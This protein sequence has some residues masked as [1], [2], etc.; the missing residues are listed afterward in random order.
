M[1][2]RIELTI[3]PEY[4]NWGLY[5]GIR[6]F[7]QNARDEETLNNHPMDILHNPKRNV[8]QIR[9]YGATLPLET[10][11]LGK[12]QKR[13]NDA[14]IGEFGE[15][16][17]L[18]CLGLIRRG[19]PVKI[20]TGTEMWEPAIVPSKQ[21][22]GCKVLAFDVHGNRAKG[23]AGV[24]VEV[25]NIQN[26]AWTLV[27][28]MF[29]WLNKPNEEQ[30]VDC[31]NGRI[32][33]EEKYKGRLY[34][35]G[36]FVQTLPGNYRYGYDMKE[37]K[38]D[39]DR[40]VAEGWSLRWELDRLWRQA[41]EQKE[42]A[43]TVLSLLNADA[44]DTA[45]VDPAYMGAEAKEALAEI[46]KAQHGEEALPVAGIG[47]SAKLMHVGKRGV[48]VSKDAHRVLK[49][50][51]GDAGAAL[52]KAEN[53]VTIFYGWNDLEDSEREL[54]TKVFAAL[55]L[56]REDIVLDKVRVVDFRGDSTL[57]KWQGGEVY[58][59]RE[60]LQDPAELIAT[61]A[62]EFAHSEGSDGDVFHEREIE[63]IL[64]VALWAVL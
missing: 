55:S 35:K 45:S 33:L 13:G 2:R 3:D 18:G 14:A 61:V 28:D 20:W 54:L 23:K 34:V 9:S 1:A 44:P 64:S 60:V 22:E 56:A 17:K 40:R 31:Q 50:I 29:L 12:T 62:H 36:I 38:L 24:L 16:Y 7:L 8:L 26:D 19:F 43:G 42:L 6:E 59:A 41:A 48:V 32:L 15:G 4:V 57:G 25:F 51:I 11:L 46:F 21:F 39:R 5:E 53:D 27:Q 30:V 47:D 10:L 58:V 63:R 52:E 49:E 37:V